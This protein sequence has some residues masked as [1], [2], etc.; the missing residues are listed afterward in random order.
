MDNFDFFSPVILKF[1]REIGVIWK[2]DKL[3]SFTPEK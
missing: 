3:K 1:G 2:S